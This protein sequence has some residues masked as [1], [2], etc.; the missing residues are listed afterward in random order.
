MDTPYT[1]ISCSF[2]D[3]L[4]ALATT[5]QPCQLV[6]RTQPDSPPVTYQGVIA[7]LFIQDKVEYLRLT[8]GFT[9]RLDNLLAVDQK[10]RRDVC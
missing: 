4:E 6:Y 5:R 7:D 8:D 3:E 2:Y 9:L 1:P 10:E